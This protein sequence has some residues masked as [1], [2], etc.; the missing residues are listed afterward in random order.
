MTRFLDDDFT[1]T[2]WE[3]SV[4]YPARLSGSIDPFIFVVIADAHC[5]ETPSSIK[6][7]RGLEHLGD[8]ANRLRL[9]FDAIRQLDESEKPEFLVLL[10]DIGIEAGEPVLDEAPCLAHA[11]AGNHDW[12]SRRQQLRELFPLDFGADGQL[13]D[14]YTFEK[15]GVR[16]IAICNAGT[17]NEHTGQL[18]SEDIR[19]PGQA[20]WIAKQLEDAKGPKVVLGH[21]PPQPEPFDPRQY[22]ESERHKYLPFMGD[23]DSAFLSAQL[24]AHAPT[25]AF[26]GHLH[27]ET[28]SYNCGSSRVHVLRSCNWNHDAQPI[29]FTQV[30]VGPSSLAIRE[31]LTGRY[32]GDA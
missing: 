13:S 26:F 3:R 15:G 4:S 2:Q 20:A 17:G 31:I 24:R 10:G 12:G 27:R 9:C 23:C 29:G 28:V 19:P 11:I 16:F 32:K 25:A 21:C 8:G 22:M 1:L 14:Y 7:G 30:R 6:H 18:S 5:E